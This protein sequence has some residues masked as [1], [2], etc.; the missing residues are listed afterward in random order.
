MTSRV[1]AWNAESE[2]VPDDAPDGVGPDGDAELDAE[3]GPT[4]RSPLIGSLPPTQ[5]KIRQNDTEE[6]AES[7]APGASAAPSASISIA[8]TAPASERGL[9]THVVGFGKSQ[10]L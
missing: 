10:H 3:D 8:H 4:R 9:D 7:G 2:V 6:S 1:H 5:S